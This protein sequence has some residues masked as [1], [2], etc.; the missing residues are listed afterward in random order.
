MLFM[1]VMCDMRIYTF[2]RHAYNIIIMFLQVITK[3][4]FERIANK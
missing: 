1:K 4:I 3:I 2:N